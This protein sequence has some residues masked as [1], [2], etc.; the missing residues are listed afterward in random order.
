MSEE[1]L[2]RESVA[3]GRPVPA[4]VLL[5]LCLAAVAAV[6]V[7]VTHPP[8]CKPPVEIAGFKIFGC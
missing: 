1:H 3:R 2:A 7:L 5:C 6:I 8:D 4:A